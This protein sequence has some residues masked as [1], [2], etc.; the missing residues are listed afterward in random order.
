MNMRVYNKLWDALEK[1]KID[2]T[3]LIEDEEGSK[4][5][6]VEVITWDDLLDIMRILED[7]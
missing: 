7:E 3:V 1:A 6:P 4:H 2:V 5:I